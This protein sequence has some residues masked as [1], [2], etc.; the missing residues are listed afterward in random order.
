MNDYLAVRYTEVLHHL[1]L[2]LRELDKARDAAA[3][4]CDDDEL[5]RK[6]VDYKN[7]LIRLTSDALTRAVERAT[8]D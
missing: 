3:R 8:K 4:P 2:A 5:Y 6:I 7:D 1:H